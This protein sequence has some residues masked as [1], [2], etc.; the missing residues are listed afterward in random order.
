MLL[1]MQNLWFL[2]SFT[3]ETHAKEPDADEKN[4]SFEEYVAELRAIASSTPGFAEWMR[5][6]LSAMKAPAHGAC[7][8]DYL[9]SLSPEALKSAYLAE[10][11][12]PVYAKYLQDVYVHMHEWL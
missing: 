3:S 8:F 7:S 6:H 9:L 5:R 4:L 2:H 1:G 12:R 11:R 10:K